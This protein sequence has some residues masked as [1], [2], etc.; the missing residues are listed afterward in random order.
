MMDFKIHVYFR[1]YVH[2]K[3]TM[4]TYK[5]IVVRTVKAAKLADFNFN[6]LLNYHADLPREMKDELMVISEKL[7]ERNVGLVAKRGYGAGT[8]F[9][10]IVEEALSTAVVDRKQ[11]VLIIIDGDAY[12]IDDVRFLRSIRKISE[13]VITTNS[14]LGLAQRTNV[15]LPMASG[16]DPDS[17]MMR[18]IDEIYLAMAMPGLPAIETKEIRSPPA[19]KK[20]GDPVPGFYCFNGTHPGLQKLFA[21]AEKDAI[22]A[23]MSAYTGD[24]YA[25]LAASKLG[26]IVTE[27][28]PLKDNPPGSFTIENIP[29]KAGELGKTSVRDSLVAAVKSEDNKKIMEQ[30]YPSHLVERVRK[31]ILQSV[32]HK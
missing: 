14:L 6:I 18:E 9:F 12:P 20:F 10:D 28:M 23:N 22:R 17:E 27:P 31:M 2:D 25:V 15:I 3:D 13:K 1:H 32:A 4:D 11:F 7:I 16:N 30:F 24:C 26:K 5:R 19:Y 8:A 29:S 21:G